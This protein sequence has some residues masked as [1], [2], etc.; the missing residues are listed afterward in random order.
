M[1]G[2]RRERRHRRFLNETAFVRHV[3]PPA[4]R[5]GAQ[6]QGTGLFLKADRDVAGG[7]VFHG[8]GERRRSNWFV[9]KS[10]KSPEEV[11]KERAWRSLRSQAR[12][13]LFNTCA[14]LL[15][16][17][18][19]GTFL[20]ITHYPAPSTDPNLNSTRTLKPWPHFTSKMKILV[21]NTHPHTQ[22]YDRNY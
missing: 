8:T 11:K 6:Q 21:L 7:P 12:F 1:W 17:I 3:P 20:D 5:H 2:R 10:A 15:I 9:P 13:C 14:H 16:S 22:S 19:V 18:L 4:G